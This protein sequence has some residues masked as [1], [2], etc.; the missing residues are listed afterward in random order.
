MLCIGQDLPNDLPNKDNFAIF[1][2]AGEYSA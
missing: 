2:E 1:N